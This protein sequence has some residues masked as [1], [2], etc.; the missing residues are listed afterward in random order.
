MVPLMPE[1]AGKIKISIDKRKMIVSIDDHNILGKRDRI[2]W[3]RQ[4]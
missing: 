3:S 4:N 1:V 2:N